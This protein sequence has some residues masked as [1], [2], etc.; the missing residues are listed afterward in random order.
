MLVR[1][2]NYLLERYY[3]S[4]SIF[5]FQVTHDGA[6][7]RR[8]S[9]YERKVLRHPLHLSF[10]VNGVQAALVSHCSAHLMQ[11]NISLYLIH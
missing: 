1:K 10:L 9:R 2:L 8:E 6:V 5:L 7:A 11:T 3:S 4:A